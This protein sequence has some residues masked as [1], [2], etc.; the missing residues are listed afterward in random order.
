[1]YAVVVKIQIKPENRKEFIE[2]MLDDARGSVQNE[3]DCLLFNV[4]ED[5]TDSN[6]LH[7]YEVYRDEQAFERHKQMPHFTNWLEKT[8]NWLAQPLS[9]ATGT[10]LFPAD[11]CWKKQ[12]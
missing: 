10:H 6:C 12:V 4:V 9:I 3:P 1:M 5:H 2:S 11:G 7:L 8:K